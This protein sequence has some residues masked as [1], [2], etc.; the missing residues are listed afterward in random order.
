MTKSNI[1]RLIAYVAVLIAVMY[2]PVTKICRF[3][4]PAEPPVVYDFEMSF[5]DPYDPMRG[6]YVLLDN[7]YTVTLDGERDYWY[8]DLLYG[9]PEVDEHG[10]ARIGD[11]Q[12]NM[13]EKSG[14]IKVTYR[15]GEWSDDGEYIG[16]IVEMPF[17]RFYMNEERAIAADGLMKIAR[18]EMQK[19]IIRTHVYSDGVCVPVDILIDGKSIIEN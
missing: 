11:L 15:W 17:D 6:R 7:L 13:P 2:Y 18:S 14:F 5:L 3:E 12:R 9:I 8:G 4:W 19:V 1:V 16:G 10:I